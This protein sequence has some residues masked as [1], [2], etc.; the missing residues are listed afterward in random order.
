MYSSDLNL[1][2][3]DKSSEISPQVIN[4]EKCLL[5]F[6]WALYSDIKLYSDIIGYS[7]LYSDI[8]LTN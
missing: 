1:F 8:K 6:Y 2:S 7:A 4:Y 3:L 5:S